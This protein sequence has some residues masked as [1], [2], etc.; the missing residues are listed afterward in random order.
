M[1]FEKI[2]F[3][4]GIRDKAP[5]LLL[6]SN[7]ESQSCKGRDESLITERSSLQERDF[8][9]Q[10]NDQSLRD[11]WV[12]VIFPTSYFK[13]TSFIS[14]RKVETMISSR[15][16]SEVGFWCLL[17]VAQYS[18]TWSTVTSLLDLLLLLATARFKIRS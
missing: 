11:P 8:F 15:L 5:S 4:T 13:G 3:K 1:N 2:F 18:S 12:K 10:G 17:L 14:S 16:F 6:N 9:Q 7:S